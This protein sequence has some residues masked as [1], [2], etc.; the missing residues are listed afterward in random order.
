MMGIPPFFR[1]FAASPTVEQRLAG[2]PQA[3]AGL[4]AALA[5]ADRRRIAR[6]GFRRAARRAPMPG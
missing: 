3:L 1:A 6:A 5:R 4:G 2:R